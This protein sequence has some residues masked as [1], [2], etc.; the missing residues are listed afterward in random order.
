MNS[1][2][3]WVVQHFVY[4][5][6]NKAPRDSYQIAYLRCQTPGR[7]GIE[8]YRWLSSNYTK[9]TEH[10]LF[11]GFGAGAAPVIYTPNNCGESEMSNNKNCRSRGFSRCLY[12]M[13]CY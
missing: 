11:G 10:E 3:F 9:Q 2:L 8:K 5:N 7:M 13:H 12:N 4:A 1:T 6:C